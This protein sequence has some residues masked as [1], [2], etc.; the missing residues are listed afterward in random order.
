MKGSMALFNNPVMG[1]TEE[2]QKVCALDFDYMIY[3]AGIV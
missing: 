2:Q 1:L 3:K